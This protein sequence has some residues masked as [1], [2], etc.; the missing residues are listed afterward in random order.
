MSRSTKYLMVSL[1][2]SVVATAISSSVLPVMLSSLI[3][4]FSLESM[5]EG[6]MSSM[7]SAGA[8]TALLWM[9]TRR[10][11]AEKKH[12]IRFFGLLMAGMLLLEGLPI[13]FALFL[14]A[15]FVMGVG[16]GITDASQSAFLVE[17]CPDGGAKHMCILHGVFGVGSLLTPLVLNK[18][19]AVLNWRSVYLITGTFCILLIAQFA[20]SSGILG[21]HEAAVSSQRVPTETRGA[22][23]LFQSRQ[24]SGLLG[25][26]FFSAAGQS[27]IIV[28]VFRYVSVY[29]NSPEMAS[30][31]LSLFWV[32]TTASRFL[33][34]LSPFPVNTALLYGAL[35]SG[36]VW[37]AAVFVNTPAAFC[38]ACCLAGLS[39][40]M[41]MPVLLHEGS[42]LRQDQAQVPTGIIMIT[43]TI[44]QAISPL[45]ISFG[46]SRWGM[47]GAM[48]LTAVFFMLSAAV[49]KTMELVPGSE[50]V[51]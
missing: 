46:I 11:S 38:A 21:R 1:V 25:M 24:F 27:G 3:E 40:G 4:T 15:C 10:K 26:A 17:L 16:L 20:L 47:R 6:L 37:I 49:R 5:Q 9:V 33:F 12:L 34:P 13:S 42:L 19:L 7:V 32:F 31:C 39:S 2:V 35:V 23:Q 48:Y 41:F 51:R 44:A 22:K 36:T 28:W 8:L 18:M 45:V 29:L 30:I 50:R 43:K 14:A